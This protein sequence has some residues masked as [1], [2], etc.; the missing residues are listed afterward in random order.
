MKDLAIDRQ[1]LSLGGANDQPGVPLDA[2]TRIAELV[3]RYGGFADDFAGPLV[4]SRVAPLATAREGDLA[5]LTARKYLDLARESEAALLVAADLADSLPKGRRWIHPHAA[6]ALAGILEALAPSSEPWA[7][8]GAHLSEAARI[9][10]SARIAPGAV[11]H[12]GAIIGPDVEIEPN[13]VIYGN[14][15]IGARTRIGAGAVIGR[16]GFGWASGPEGAM[17]R[18]PQLGGV[19]VEEDV[20]IGPLCTI[21]AG[22]L[23]PTR[24]GRGA[25]LDAHVHVAHNV[26][27]GAGTIVAAQ[28]G[29]AGSVSVGERVQIGGQVGV[30]DHVR[31]GKGSRL[32][33]KSGVIGD[34]EAGATVAGYPAVDRLRWLR[35]MARLLR[36][37]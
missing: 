27:I 28:S 11:V 13:A 22:T 21:D 8:G 4:V 36:R 9:A 1:V 18:M 29:F 24:L 31:I 26:S 20:D 7:R 30:A 2:P 37:S 16:P 14:V 33:A 23:A 17:R 15:T 34:I 10:N 19:V 32:A 3:R 5:P 25:R 35:G 6:H 12:G